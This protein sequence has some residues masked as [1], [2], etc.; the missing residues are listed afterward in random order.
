MNMTTE[1]AQIKL[2]TRIMQGNNKSFKKILLDTIKKY[3]V[4]GNI[5]S[6][7]LIKKASEIN[8]NVYET[9]IRSAEY[10]LSESYYEFKISDDETYFLK[11]PT[12]NLSSILF[13]SA[14]EYTY[15][16]F[17]SFL[18]NNPEYVKK[19]TIPMSKSD[20]KILASQFK[21]EFEIIKL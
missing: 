3:K 15:E 18:I 12:D 6:H 5:D 19:I 8:S 14:V 4:Y 20:L 9:A 13:D 11:K 21:K 10:L 2:F 1:K 16:S 17:N 7:D